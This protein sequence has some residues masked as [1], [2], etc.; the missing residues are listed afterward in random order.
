MAGAESF[1]GGEFQGRQECEGL[2][3]CEGVLIVCEGIINEGVCEGV[4]ALAGERSA[5][6]PP[7]R[8]KIRID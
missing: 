3:F 6:V 2:V 7:A 4:N 1:I 8:D 5:K